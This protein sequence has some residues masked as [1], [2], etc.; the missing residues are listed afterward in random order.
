MRI[1]W[2]YG[3]AAVGKSATAWEVL[4]QVA[5]TGRV[6]GYVDIDQLGMSHCD[7]S[8]DPGAHRLKAEALAA[9]ADEFS[10]HGAR[11]LVVSGVLD[12]GLMAFYSGVLA[13]FRPGFVRLSVDESVLRRRLESR[14][15]YAEAWAEV[16]DDARSLDRSPVGHPVVDTGTVTPAEVAARILASLD[17]T[18]DVTLDDVPDPAGAPDQADSPID[19]PAAA[20]LIGGTT[21]V[22]KSTVGWQAF[23]AVREQRRTAFVDLRQLGFLGPDGGPVDHA[24]QA[25]SVGALWRVFRQHGAELL[26]MNGP[27]NRESELA[28]YRRALRGT[29]LSAL[30]LVADRAALTDRV[31]ARTRGEM[32]PLAGDRL[33]GLPESAVEGVAGAAWTAQESAASVDAL[34][35]LDT[36]HL[37]PVRIAGLVV[38][39]LL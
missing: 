2:L 25:R 8:V 26:V 3:P 24:L 37:A 16:A 18:L 21:A 22:G 1:L 4:N 23:M 29:P 35:A 34:D 33:V 10:R 31:R 6:T 15:I 11:T 13:P 28:L 9:V 14:G 30:R 39:E 7:E 5:S 17:V 38:G 32:A 20:V 27:V 12:L 36:T 19:D